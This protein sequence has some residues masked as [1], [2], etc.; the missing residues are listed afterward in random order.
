MPLAPAEQ[1]DSLR[2]LGA[3]SASRPGEFAFVCTGGTEMDPPFLQRIDDLWVRAV[4]HFITGE[5]DPVF[6]CVAIP[7]QHGKSTRCTKWGPA[8]AFTKAPEL[9][10]LIVSFG[11]HLARQFGRFTRNMLLNDPEV[12]RFEEAQLRVADDKSAMGRFEVQ[13]GG[14][15]V[16]CAGV[17]SS[18]LGEPAD[19]LLLDDLV[20]DRQEAQNPEIMEER[21]QWVTDVAFTRLSARASVMAVN[22]R[23]T[24]FDPMGMILK[25][26]PL[27]SGTGR[28]W[29]YH[30]MP[31]IA[32]E[33]DDLGRQPGEPLFPE[34]QPLQRLEARKAGM[35]A[36]AWN[37]IYQGNPQPDEG[38]KFAEGD[39]RSWRPTSDVRIVEI[40]TETGW[41]TVPI[42]NRFMTC[43]LA[44]GKKRANDWT[45]I[46][47]WGV[48][49]DM[50]L[51]WLANRR[52][53]TE[54][55]VS[56]IRTEFSAH[57]GGIGTIWIEA[58]GIQLSTVQQ[59]RNNG[60]PVLEAPGS[61]LDKEIRADA[62]RAMWAGHRVHIPAQAPWRAECLSELAWFPNGAHD[63]QVDVLAYS[64]LILVSG[65]I[66]I[67]AAM[68]GPDP[69]QKM[70]SRSQR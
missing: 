49:P 9:R 61:N 64:A 2:S 57:L 12:M 47:S 23:W 17:G 10:I 65:Q 15:S 31:A 20:A 14:G 16:L 33:A 1:Q 42:M 7:P 3:E 5:G 50:R 48:T 51:I 4:D 68:E 66:T 29:E 11:A 21:W 22:T 32:E 24:Q 60:L 19:I 18:I 46:A 43:D 36:H 34:L 40:E 62:A 67:G 58:V 53:R 27:M 59:A 44:A 8:W 69:K 45:V 30:R 35:T 37:S 6:A 26:Q 63:D 41:R 38:V 56:T 25:E 52:L 28:S 70:R 54:D 55:H 13:P 39:A